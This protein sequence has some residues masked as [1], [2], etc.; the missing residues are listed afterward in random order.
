[1]KLNKLHESHAIAKASCDFY[2]DPKAKKSGA[3]KKIEGDSDDMSFLKG[4]TKDRA[5]FANKM[6]KSSKGK[7]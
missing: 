3:T 6:N 7:K 2:C 5:R 4:G 1:M